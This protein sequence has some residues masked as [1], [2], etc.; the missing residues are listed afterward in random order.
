[1]AIITPND[2][3]KSVRN[4]YVNDV[5]VAFLCCQL[6]VEYSVGIRALVI[7]LRQISVFFLY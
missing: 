1:M 4:S 6:V 5:L 2:R 3:H 7:G